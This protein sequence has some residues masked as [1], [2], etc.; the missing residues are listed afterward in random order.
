[1]QRVTRL[2]NYKYLDTLK[3]YYLEPLVLELNILGFYIRV[4]IIWRL[5]FFSL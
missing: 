3:L 1:M 2:A 5:M 4:I